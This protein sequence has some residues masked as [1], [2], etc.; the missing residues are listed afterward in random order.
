[1]GFEYKEDLKELLPVYLD[2][3]VSKGDLDA[4]PRSV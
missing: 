4:Y 3:L 1:M 2:Y